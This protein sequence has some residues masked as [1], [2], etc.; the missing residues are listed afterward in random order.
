MHR[1]ESKHVA[2]GNRLHCRVAAI[3]CCTYAF[4]NVGRH[5]MSRV[6]WADFW[7]TVGLWYEKNLKCPSAISSQPWAASLRSAVSTTAS[8]IAAIASSNAALGILLLFDS[9]TRLSAGA[10]CFNPDLWCFCINFKSGAKVSAQVRSTLSSVPKLTTTR[11]M[12]ACQGG[13][14]GWP[15]TVCNEGGFMRPTCYAARPDHDAAAVSGGEPE[16]LATRAGVHP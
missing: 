7:R 12:A 5:S 13:P 14:S 2:L 3:C 8:A 16:Y 4:R 11:P 6:P 9:M 15:V 10:I 1:N